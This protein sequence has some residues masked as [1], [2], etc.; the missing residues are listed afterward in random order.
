[1]NKRKKII[2]AET[3]LLLTLLLIVMLLTVDV[4][5]I[6]PQGTSI[7]LSHLNQAVFTAV[8]TSQFWYAVTMVIGLLSILA[9]VC[10]A[11]LG[12][13]QLIQRKS[14]KK[15]DTELYVLAG[16]YVV[17][18]IVYVFFD[19]VA[20]NYRPILENG[21]TVPESSFPSSHTMLACVVLGSALLLL[22]R[23]IQNRNIRRALSLVCCLFMLLIIVGRLLAGVHWLTDILGGIL[24]G[25]LLIT[26]FS[27]AL[28]MFC[29]GKN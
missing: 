19:K 14:L 8:G 12:L 26:L 17:T 1:M 6:G 10:F 4:Q 9:V 28:D 29:K 5:P 24:I 25:G 13:W 2:L 21:S 16:L 23:Y 3:L 20:V 7:G 22:P 11:G 27:L 15:V 18:A